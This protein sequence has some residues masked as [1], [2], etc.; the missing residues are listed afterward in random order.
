MNNSI[1]S[2]IMYLQYSNS[3]YGNK[4]FYVLKFR[5]HNFVCSRFNN[6]CFENCPLFD[7]EASFNAGKKVC[8]FV[9]L[10]NRYHTLM[11]NN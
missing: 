4:K 11:T 3:L 5:K 1:Y 9:N 7:M 10:N 2:L 8:I 6:V